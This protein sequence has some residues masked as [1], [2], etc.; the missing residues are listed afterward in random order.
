MLSHWL[1][2]GRL[3][4]LHAILSPPH[5]LRTKHMTGGCL[6][7]NI[8]HG[9]VLVEV[10]LAALDFLVLRYA[11]MALQAVRWSDRGCVK[12]RETLS[13]ARRRKLSQGNRLSHPAFHWLQRFSTMTSRLPPLPQSCA[14]GLPTRYPPTGAPPDSRDSTRP[15]R[16][17]RNPEPRRRYPL[18]PTNPLVY[19]VAPVKR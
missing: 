10:I 18:C 17:C 15:H 12:A 14:S 6:T 5:N 2:L 9:V 13:A 8:V 7:I 11:I 3:G 1:G 16:L 19:P 4:Q